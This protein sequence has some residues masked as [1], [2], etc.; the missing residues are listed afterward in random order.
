MLYLISQGIG[1]GFLAGATPG[2]LQSYLIATTLT[3]GW[4]RS[5]IVIFSPLITDLPIIVLALVLLKSM[6]PNLI[7]IIQVVGG[8]YLLWM[9]YGLWRQFRRGV[10]L[11]GDTVSQGR[12]LGR[13]MI[14]NW[15]S[16]GPYIFWTTITGPMLVEGLGLSLWHGIAFLLAFYGTF[17]GFLGLYV[18]IFDRFRQLDDRVIRWIFLIA[19]LVMFFFSLSLIGQGLGFLSS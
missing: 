4:R 1:F 12:T 8:V 15:L 3:Q 16:P 18:V 19:M 14:M 6:P 5:L 17:L 9:V 11:N 7:H 13:G 2:P 10:S